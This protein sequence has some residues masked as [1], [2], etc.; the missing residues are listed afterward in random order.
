MRG[1]GAAWRGARELLLENPLTR[2]LGRV[3]LGSS[4]RR[5]ERVLCIGLA[6]AVL[7]WGL[8]T[9]TKVQT[10]IT[11]LVPQSLSSLQSLRELER[12]TGVGGQINVMIRGK[13]V[14][15][16]ATITW[17]SRYEAAVLARFGYTQ[18]H[19]CAHARLCPVF[20][21]PDLFSGHASGT[22]ATGAQH[23]RRRRAAQHHPALLLTGRD[24]ARPPRRLALLR[25]PPR[26]P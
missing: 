5:P 25:R 15:T 13:N 3:A 10:D 26:G 17:M 22:S 24:H 2:L 19:G 14:A 9:Q 21:L 1:I 6:L 18:A 8:D 23:H 12:T 20:S 4:V 11:K 16:P 7:G